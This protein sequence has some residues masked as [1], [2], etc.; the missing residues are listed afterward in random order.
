MGRNT[1]DLGIKP[2]EEQIASIDIEEC[3]QYGKWHCIIRPRSKYVISL[4]FLSYFRMSVTGFDLRLFFLD[5][6]HVFFDILIGNFRGDK[7]FLN[8]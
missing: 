4:Q 1:Y 3:E 8:D 2:T 5:L 6:H 7:V